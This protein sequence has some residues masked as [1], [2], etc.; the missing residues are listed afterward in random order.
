MLVTPE[1]IAE[2]LRAKGYKVDVVQDSIVISVKS[3]GQADANLKDI[4]ASL[5]PYQKAMMD[6]LSRWGEGQT[7]V[8]SKGRTPGLSMIRGPNPGR[9]PAEFGILYGNSKEDFERLISQ[10]DILDCPVESG[11]CAPEEPKNLPH[12]RKLERKGKRW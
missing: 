2:A 10:R 12:Y 6:S 9:S 4:E 1:D 5:Y 8:V 7:F 11:F 3:E